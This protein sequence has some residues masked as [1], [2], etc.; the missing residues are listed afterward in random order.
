MHTRYLVWPVH[1][2]NGSNYR[3][4]GDYSKAFKKSRRKDVHRQSL[5]KHSRAS[6]SAST[7]DACADIH[8][9]GEDGGDVGDVEIEH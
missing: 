6:S 1:N 4:G 9:N 8:E 2:V 5:Q 7:S 3:E